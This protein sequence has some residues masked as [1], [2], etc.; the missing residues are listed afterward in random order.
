MEEVIIK[1]E[2]EKGDN[3][4]QIDNVSKKLIELQAANKN[5]I[6]QNKELAKQGKENSQEYIENTRQ[7]EINKQK[8]SEATASR[9]GLIQTLIAEDNSIKALKVRNA[10]LIKQRDL[11]NTSTANGKAQ[12][13]AINEELDRN[14]KVI[15]DNSS[16]LEKQRFNIGNYKSALDAIVPGLGGFIDGIQGATKASLAFIATPIGIV[17]AALAGI[18]LT[19][20]AYFKRTE[21]GGDK[22][23]KI[24]FTMEAIFGQ[25][26]NVAA[27][28]GDVI[29]EA[30]ENPKK[31]IEELGNFL[32]ENL[33][34]R[35][36]G[37][38]ELIPKLGEAISL[39]FEGEFAQAGEVALNA[40]GKVALGVEDTTGLIGKFIDETGKL[41]DEAI[42]QGERLSQLDKLI[43]DQERALTIQ[44]AR[45]ALETA[46]IREE[47]LRLEGD[48][49]KKRILEAIQLE[50]RLSNAEVAAAQTRLEQAKIEQQING[51]TGASRQLVAEAEAAVINAQAE[52]F[53][54]TLRFQKELARLDKEELDRKLKQAEEEKRIAQ[55]TFDFYQKLAKETFDRSSQ[56]LEDSQTERLTILKEG[57]LNDL[58]AKEEFETQLSA[59]EVTALE[60]RKAFL[61][62]NGLDTVAIEA[63]IADAKIKQKEREV[64]ANKKLSEERKKQDQQELDAK[65]KTVDAGVAVLQ[66]G[67]SEAR[68]IS[69]AGAS[70][71]TYRAAAAALEP[72]PIGAGPV[73]GPVLATLTI[74][75]GLVQVARILGVT[76]S[77]GG[78]LQKFYGGGIAQTGGVLNGPS[79]AR[80]GIPFS[81]GGKLGFEAEGGET[82]INKKS[83]KMFRRELSAINVAGGGVAFGRGGVTRYQ[84]G[85]IIS[86]SQ[87]QSSFQIAESRSQLRDAVESV[88]NS[89]PPIVVTVEDINARVDEVSQTTQK[90]TII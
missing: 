17:L 19:V 35:I 11:L 64:A 82:I 63:S 24:I 3:E 30:F 87:T 62:S 1:I 60:E 51:V 75:R 16:A 33:I 72:P 55:E 73:F 22:L 12:I 83:S 59:L 61:I 36:E 39:L 6:A 26:M 41:V 88:M 80:G 77:R 32:K 86:G 84:T 54:S 68:E 37:F 23:N 48:E 31:A 50:E 69:A 38:F 28:V 47:A 14:N 78:I 40:I 18:L 57:Y 46:K 89:M 5:L 10:E 49:R 34:N 15:N 85:S 44:R 74:I 7:I 27:Q 66:E 43:G 65:R 42:K 8:I 25:L 56:A 53:Q 9:K 52:R 29:V 81:V 67:F 90:A 76:F 71:S 2:L 58:I 20:S 45:T 79:H 13:A 70:I 21:E 4:R